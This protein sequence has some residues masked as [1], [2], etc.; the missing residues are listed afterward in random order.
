MR[1]RR[2]VRIESHHSKPFLPEKSRYF[3]RFRK[4]EKNG[5]A[6]LKTRLSLR[7]MA[8]TTVACHFRVSIGASLE[9][10]ASLI[11]EKFHSDRTFVLLPSGCFGRPAK[12][13]H[14]KAKTGQNWTIL[15][16]KNG[17]KKFSDMRVRPQQLPRGVPQA[18]PSHLGKSH[19]PPGPFLEPFSFS[20]GH[21]ALTY[22]GTAVACR[23]RVEP[24]LVA[25]IFF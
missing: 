12:A 2:L 11:I 19:N 1:N 22:R 6:T 15:T 9:F 16:A 17:R 21:F 5:R 24:N 13:S 3:E 23:Y 10:S 8:Q 14:L 20:V 18:T 7:P 4:Y 25:S